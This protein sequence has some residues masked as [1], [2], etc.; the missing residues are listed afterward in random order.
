LLQYRAQFISSYFKQEYKKAAASATATRMQLLDLSKSRRI[1]SATRVIAVVG[2]S[3]KPERPSNQV[4]RYLL[5]RG[6]RVIPVNPGQQTILG[7]PC[8]PDLDSAARA[9]T[10]RIDL[11]NIF[12]RSDQVLPVVAAAIAVGAGA[13]W[14]QEGVINREAAR[15]AEAAG[16]EV[17]MDQCIKTV[18]EQLFGPGSPPPTG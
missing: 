15:L 17:V 13:V 14:M 2:L 12:R 8:Y 10:V 18:D 3:P 7:L 9:L 16:L 1:L 11:V 6:Y 5:G 4:A